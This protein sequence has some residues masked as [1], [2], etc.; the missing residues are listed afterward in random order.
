MLPL[1]SNWESRVLVQI[2][3]DTQIFGMQ[4]YGGISRYFAGMAAEMVGVPG[5]DATVVAPMHI[6]GYLGRLPEGVVMGN[7]VRNLRAISLARRFCSAVVCDFLQRKLKPDIVH[8]TYYHSFPGT[9]QGACGAVTVYDMIQER[10]P[11]D[12][13]PGGLIAKLKRIAVHRADHVICISEQTRRDLLSMYPIIE[14]RV[15][16]TLLGYDSLM[17]AGTGATAEEFRTRVFGANRPFLLFVGRRPGYKNFDGLLRAYVSSPWLRKNFSLLLFGGGGI[18]VDEAQQFSRMGILD[19]VRYL[20]G[21]DEILADSYR[22]ASVFV[23]PSLYEGFGIPPLEAMSVDCPVACSNNS[24]I[25]EVV[26]DA[27]AYFDPSTPE[28]IRETLERVL[29]SSAERF[30]LVRL[31]RVRREMFSWRKCAEDTVR[32]YRKMVTQ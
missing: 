17:D 2:V 16:V 15:S 13:P 32:V 1:N 10:F 31:G 27:G 21:G 23:F 28:S 30:E 12:F 11:Q 7:R 22:H 8:K 20:G 5:V 24:S 4:T 19:S 29:G 9:P 3:F 18:T 25:P 14:D 26:G 6:N